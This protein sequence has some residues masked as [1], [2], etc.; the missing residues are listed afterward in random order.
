MRRTLAA[1][2]LIALSLCALIAEEAAGQGASAPQLSFSLSGTVDPSASIYLENE[3]SA[4]RNPII[5][6]LAPFSNASAAGRIDGKLSF[7]REYVSLGLLDFSFKDAAQLDHGSGSTLESMSFAVNELYT[8]LNFGDLL[9]LRLGKQ[10][11]SWGAGFVFNPSDPVN[12]PKDPTSQR[13][14]REG[15]PALKAEI[16][17]KPVS[18]MTFAVL[19]DDYRETG[20]GAKLST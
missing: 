10:R 2:S 7:S 17:A 3:D 5:P 1:I 19:Y 16:I 13:S 8:D 11:L 18:L 4:F 6:G 12:P 20:Y 14:V 9:Y 15:V